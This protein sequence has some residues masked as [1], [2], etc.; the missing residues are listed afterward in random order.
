[1][2]QAHQL[3]RWV[4]AGRRRYS[5]VIAV[6]SGKGGVG[7]TSFSVNLAI[8]MARQGQRVAILDGDLGLGNIDIV[9]GLVP[10]YTLSDVIFGDKSIRDVVIPGPEGTWIIA[11]GNGV[12]E[13]ANVSDGHLDKFMTE[14]N[15][16]DDLLDILLIDT[17]AGIS[18]N[19]LTFLLASH[20]VIVVTTPELTSITDA[21]GVIKAVATRNHDASI[22]VVVNKV[23]H[24]AMAK[25]VLQSLSAVANQF[26]HTP[27]RLELLGYL[28]YDP[29]VSQ[30]IQEQVPFVISAPRARISTAIRNIADRLIGVE[31]N[32]EATGVGRLF[33]RMMALIQR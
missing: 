28:P 6:T 3:R 10:T 24:E 33:R 16:L 26:V 22:K 7:K 19:V 18:R 11:G 20:E 8:S 14:V 31:E 30:A 9:L 1:M 25:K 21:Y 15:R 27:V 29:L 23:P 5:R 2:D 4:S 13:L 12:Y 32:H 17:G